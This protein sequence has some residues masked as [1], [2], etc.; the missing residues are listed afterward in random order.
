[1]RREAD[2][3]GVR[4]CWVRTEKRRLGRV[5]VCE[6]EADI[7]HIEGLCGG[8][9][10]LVVYNTLLYPM[11]GGLEVQRFAEQGG[12]RLAVPRAAQLKGRTHWSALDVPIPRSKLK[13]LHTFS[14]MT[15]IQDYTRFLSRTALRRARGLTHTPTQFDSLFAASPLPPLFS[16]FCQYLLI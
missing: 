10:A 15:K 7:D 13:K 1:M 9:K 5:S 6:S 14:E 2:V 8:S 12:N 3:R 11:Y 4:R 16:F